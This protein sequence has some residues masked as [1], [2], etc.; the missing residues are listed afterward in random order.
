MQL[1][2]TA[3]IFQGFMLR[4]DPNKKASLKDAK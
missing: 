3:F 1:G 4:I 2:F